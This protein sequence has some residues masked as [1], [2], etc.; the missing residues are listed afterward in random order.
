MKSIFFLLLLFTSLISKGQTAITGKVIDNSKNPIGFVSIKGDNNIVYFSDE[1]GNFSLN[2]TKEKEIFTF[3]CVGYQSL[4]KLIDKD[5]IYLT[6]TLSQIL[7]QLNEVKVLSEKANYK[8]K[9]LGNKKVGLGNL[10]PTPR[11]QYA[12]FIPNAENEIGIIKSVSL[13]MR[14]PIGG[15]AKGPFR[16]RIYS[17]DTITKKPGNDLL[18]ANLIVNAEKQWSWFTIELTKYQI[19]FP[20]DGFFVAMEILPTSNYEKG[21]LKRLGSYQNE[22][23]YPSIGY[24]NSKKEDNTWGFYPDKIT[25]D[26][27]WRIIKNINCSIKAEILTY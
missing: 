20:K 26:G 11:F 18:N 15:S 9:I 3:S 13:F 2:I 6:I 4:N 21:E 14:Q 16:L 10:L 17:L 12:L 24:V 7:Y 23:K 19:A 27:R 8:T 1:N 5:S 22:Y 25:S